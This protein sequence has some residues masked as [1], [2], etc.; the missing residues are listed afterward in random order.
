[1]ENFKKMFKDK[2]VR[3]GSYSI[4]ATIAVIAILVFVNLIAEALNKSID[5]T[6]EKL[7]SLSEDTKTIVSMIDK[8][9][10]IYKLFKTGSND[11]ITVTANEILKNYTSQ[12]SH[13]KVEERDPYIHPKFVENYKIDS[14]IPVNSLI[15]EHENRFKIIKPS[16]FYSTSAL[17]GEEVLDIESK[18]TNAI[19]FVCLEKTPTIYYVTGHSEAEIPENVALQLNSSG[20]EIKSENLLKY[21]SIPEDCDFIMITTPEKDYSTQEVDLINNFLAKDGRAIICLNF[22]VK[23]FPNLESIINAYGVETTNGVIHENNPS[24]YYAGDPDIII[25]NVIDFEATKLFYEKGFS[26]RIKFPQPLKERKIQKNSLTLNPILTTS[27]N[28]YSKY[29]DNTESAE[30]SSADESGPFTIGYA[31]I[32]SNYSDMPHTTKLI[33]IGSSAFLDT[34]IDNA[35][36]GFNSQFI[37]QNF[38]WLNDSSTSLYIQPK[39][40]EVKEAEVS[41]S[42]EFNITLITCGIIPF[43]ILLIGFIVWIKRRNK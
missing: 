31:I 20:Y 36:G 10:T 14:E 9:V 1:M 35:T 13:I 22:S 11:D 23:N 21:K 40:L 26:P 41:G 17:T 24:N 28:S 3:Y 12:S 7:F 34:S 8:D 42:D 5:L 38:N 15:V 27:E 2:R 43:G 19:S 25:P 4:F 6:D 16:E 29:N 30:F 18:I 32:D 37:V 33:V 39:S